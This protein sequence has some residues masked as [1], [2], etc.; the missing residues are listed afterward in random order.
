MIAS[1]VPGP[2]SAPP[3]DPTGARARKKLLYLA[4]CD[5]DL[6]VTGVTVRMGAFVEALAR[7]YDITLINMAGSGHQVAPEI[8]R[9][10]RDRDNRLG[11]TARVRV[12]FSRPGYFLFSPTLYREADKRLRSGSFDYLLADYGLA[13]VYGTLLARRHRVPLIYSSANVEYRAYYEQARYDLRRAVLA[14]YVYWAERTA[15]RA[16]SLVVAIS[17][18]DGTAFA[19][20]IPRHRIEVIPQ[21]FDPAVVNPHYPPPPTSPAV[22]LFV[23]N[24][25]AEH[26]RRAA[27][28]LVNEVVPPVTAARPDVRFQLVG[29]DPPAD[30]IGPNVE[31]T[32]FVDDLGPYLR[33]A[34]LVIA[35]MV[36]AHGMATKIISA[37][38]Y[39]KTVLATPEG[40][41]SIR[42]SR[43]L[44]VSSLNSFPQQVVALLATSPP[45]QTG[46]FP[47]L[48]REFGWPSLIDRLHRRIEE[49]CSRDNRWADRRPALGGRV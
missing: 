32:G 38:A 37:L 22:V 18:S 5:P 40:A 21:G 41:G 49:M 25:R 35:P 28:Q 31:C 45:V 19:R 9:R 44:V 46:E 17:D 30:L 1:D 29:A 10:F 11:V 12:G 4:L 7:I 33:R 13:A 39:G 2:A 14:P 42:R 34:N 36:F 23:G 3:R 43:Q 48:C 16:A 24:F 15:C 26:N 27:R 8:E 47:A 20:W 6:P